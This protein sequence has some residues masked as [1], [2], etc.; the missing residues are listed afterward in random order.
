MNLQL[1]LGL[2]PL[3]HLSVHEEQLPPL[4]TKRQADREKGNNRLETFN[5]L[6][7]SGECVLPVNVASG[8][9]WHVCGA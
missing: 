7:E 9:C 3:A 5:C 1:G 2:K 8:L 6:R 4:Y